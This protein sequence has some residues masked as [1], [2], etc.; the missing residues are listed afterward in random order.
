MEQAR[1]IRRLKELHGIK[2]GARVDLGTSEIIS[3]VPLNIT[4]R[5]MRNLDKLNDL[6][7]RCKL[8]W[9]PTNCPRRSERCCFA[10]A[11]FGRSIATLTGR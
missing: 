11:V 9:T 6:I 10:E 7:P 5:Q 1:L 8:W 3:E 2:Q 4:D